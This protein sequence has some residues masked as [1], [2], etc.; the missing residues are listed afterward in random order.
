[1]GL[2]LYILLSGKVPFPGRDEREIITNVIK[3]TFHFEHEAFKNVSEECKDLI[4]NLLNKDVNLRY[5]AQ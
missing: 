4:R 5:T 3:G 2:V 1:M